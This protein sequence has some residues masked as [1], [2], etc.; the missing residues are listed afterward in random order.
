MI[1]VIFQLSFMP[2]PISN[3]GVLEDIF[4]SGD[5]FLDQGKVRGSEV[6]NQAE[7][8]IGVYNIYNVLFALGVAL[9]VLV[10]AILGIKFMMGSIEE[11]AKIKEA[12]IPYV[13]GCIVVFGAFGIWKLVMTL[14]GNIFN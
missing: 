11:Q 7:L 1:M 5:K 9:S 12:L 2:M 6:L 10:G 13:F 4:E 3:A 14:G 8:K